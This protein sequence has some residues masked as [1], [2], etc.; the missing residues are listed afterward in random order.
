MPKAGEAITVDDMDMM[1][2]A[3]AERQEKHD[4]PMAVSMYLVFKGIGNRFTPVQCVEQEWEG[5][6]QDIPK[7]DE[8]G[9]QP[10]CPNG[11]T[12]HAGP[13]LVLG[14]LQE[15]I[16]PSDAQRSEEEKT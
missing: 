14:W 5:I 6:Q 8:N 4:E 11:H 3:M 7:R 10:K 13:R 1:L 15:D 9:D 12:I 16:D 2:E